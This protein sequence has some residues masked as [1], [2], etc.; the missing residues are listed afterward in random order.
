MKLRDCVSIDRKSAILLLLLFS[1]QL[2]TV[3]IGLA[4]VPM[5]GLAVAALLSYR[6]FVKIS[7]YIYLVIGYLVASAIYNSRQW[8][9][10]YIQYTPYF[11]LLALGFWILSIAV[12]Q[13][14]KKSSTENDLSKYTLFCV[15]SA[16]VGVVINSPLSIATPMDG[17][18][19][20]FNEK[21]LFGYY[22][23]I[24]SCA[25]YLYSEV[26]IKWVFLLCLMMYS[27]LVIESSRSLLIYAS[28]IALYLDILDKRYIKKTI[29][30][31]LIIV[32]PL[33]FSG[34]FNGVIGKLEIIQENAGTIGRYAATY[35]VSQLNWNGLLFGT[36]FG[37]YLDT[38]SAHVAV[39]PELPYDYAGSFLLEMVVEIGVIQTA[40]LYFGIAK[41]LF[42]RV[43]F[44]LIST[45]IMLTLTGGKQDLQMIFGLIM[46]S[47][48]YRDIKKK[49]QIKL[50]Q[51]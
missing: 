10:D 47:L 40:I 21:G 18:M 4:S 31:L 17:E 24:L 22:I 12:L 9:S 46:F 5:F 38:R 20:F 25:V 29:S 27:F 45:V 37:T 2:W 41:I 7:P 35:T 1:Q 3:K 34:A 44:L 23:S 39:I 15:I 42:G 11:T 33:Y 26:R 28:I 16:F 19:G 49:H 8:T 13:Y 6:Q 32:I 30:L 50:H 43:S 14:L 36:G 48:F 51:V